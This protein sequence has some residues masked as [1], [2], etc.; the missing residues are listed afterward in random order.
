M[1]V[2]ATLG[3]GIMI[4]SFRATVADWL[5]YTL[6]GDL[7]IRQADGADALPP[8]VR[9]L[10][11]SLPQVAE[12][13]AGRHARIHTDR[14]T[15]ELLALEP[16][17]R[18]SRGFRF[19]APPLPRLWPRYTRGELLLVSEPF[20]YRHRLRTGDRLRLQT[21]EGELSLPIGGIFYDYGSDRGLVSLVRSRYARLWHDPGI[22]TIG[23]YLRPGVETAAA[24]AALTRLLGNRMDGLEIR[25]NREIRERSLAVFDRTFA[26]TRVLRLLAIGVAFIG[27]LSALMA[28]QLERGRELA[29]LRATGLTRGQLVRLVLLQTG[30]MGLYAGLFALPLGWLMSDLLIEVINRRAFGW[31]IFARLPAGILAETLVLALGAALLAALYPAWRMARVRPA[32]ALREE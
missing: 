31:T 30:L 23:I 11:E 6:R 4:G 15:V 16:A 29:L 8:G 2:A 28:L 9:D 26:I 24:E 27:V 19:A 3:V 25:S 22:S 14:G 17:T 21:D 12:T 18:S 32:R 20:A 10:V 13:S 1:A 7:Y 5:G